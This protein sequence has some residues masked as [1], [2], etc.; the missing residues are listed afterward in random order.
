M[1]KNSPPVPIGG[2][3]LSQA[4]GVINDNESARSDFG[5]ETWFVLAEAY[6]VIGDLNKAKDAFC[7]AL[8]YQARFTKEHQAWAK[9]LWGKVVS[10]GDFPF[11]QG[12]TS[13]KKSFQI[14]SADR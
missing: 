14:K 5:V 10:S 6:L 7:Q 8:I 11:Q 4:L 3:T 1:M 12:L 9:E 13:E 2:Y